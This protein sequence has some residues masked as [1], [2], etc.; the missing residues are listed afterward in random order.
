MNYIRDLFDG[1]HETSS[2]V[3]VFA[4]EFDSGVPD[5]AMDEG[6]DNFDGCRQTGGEFLDFPSEVRELSASI[7]DVRAEGGNGSIVGV[8]VALEYRLL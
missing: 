2:G 3:L 5:L 7:V 8:L 4:A 1:C 6:L